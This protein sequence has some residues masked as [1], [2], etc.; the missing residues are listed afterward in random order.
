MARALAKK[1]STSLSIPKED[2]EV[3]KPIHAYGFDSL[4]ALEIRYWHR[5]EIKVELAV[6]EILG[7][8]SISLLSVLAARNS[9]FLQASSI[10]RAQ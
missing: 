3:D 9:E 7:S 6:F 10:D 5:K 4:V 8:K 1:P 2:T